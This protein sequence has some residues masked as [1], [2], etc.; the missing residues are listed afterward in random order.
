[1]THSRW[2]DDFLQHMEEQQQD[3]FWYGTE[4]RR[5]HGGP[6]VKVEKESIG[7]DPGAYRE[8]P[9]T[10]DDVRYMRRWSD[11]VRVGFRRMAE[12]R[13]F[14]RFY[15]PEEENVPTFLHTGGGECADPSI[16]RS[17]I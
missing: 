14:F 10:D 15:T 11:Y 4:R 3:D 6:I 17:L 12:R 9:F 1:M 5:Y 7:F 2:Q 13:Q 8:I 16:T